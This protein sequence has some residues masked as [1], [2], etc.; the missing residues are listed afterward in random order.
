MQMIHQYKQTIGVSRASDSKIFILKEDT[1]SSFP[2]DLD[3]KSLL[4]HN[5]SITVN[6]P[7]IDNGKITYKFDIE[8]MERQWNYLKKY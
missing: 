7:I 2:L 3:I 4:K 6:N 8:I 1:R 5:D